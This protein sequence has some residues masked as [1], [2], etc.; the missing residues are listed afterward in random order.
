MAP[1]AASGAPFGAPLTTKRGEGGAL[2]ILWWQAPTIL[3]IHTNNG[4]KDTD[5]ASIV[6]EPL[7]RIS[8][9]SL[10]PDIPVLAKEIPSVQ[11]GTIAADYTS[12]TWKLKD[13]ITWSDGTPFTAEDVKYTFEYVM[14]PKTGSTSTTVYSDISKVDVLDPTTVKVTFKAPAAA[15]FIPFVGDAGEIVPK[16]ILS[17]CPDTRNCEFNTK[18]I[19]TGPYVVTDFKPGDTVN[20]KAN[21]K[22]REPNA[23]YFA[24]IEMKGGG[25]ATTAAKAVQTGQTDYAWNLQVA[26]EIIKQLQDAGK[27]VATPP[28][29]SVEQI[30]LNQADPRTETDGELSSA[31][32]KNP[33]FA[34]PMVRKAISYAI[35]RDSIAKNLY[36]PA[37]T[38]GNTIIPLVRGDVGKA[39]TYDLKKAGDLLDQAGWK[40]GADGIREKGGVK[41]NFTFRTSVNPVRDKTGQ[42]M[43]DSFKQLGIGF[44]LKPVD[45]SVFFGRPDNPDALSRFTVDMEM[46]STGSTRPDPQAFFEQMTTDQFATK[47]NNWGNGNVMKWSNPDYDKLFEQLKRELDPEK[48]KVLYNKLDET[49]ADDG[50]IIPIVVR[51]DVFAY[52][53]DLINTQFSPFSSQVWNI[54]HWSLKK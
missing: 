19:G 7:A 22:F 40:K 50:V 14:E 32:S 23:P 9:T 28:G 49:L 31:K 35:D 34:D 5:A 48:R 42:V 10:V 1:A 26:P 13:G 47:A 25:D 21:D 45:A 2:R 12:V 24:T 18:P 37:G 16:H 4:T 3:N 43:K 30:R 54:G 17:K 41:M 38:A 11:A 46:Y 36:G 53:P 20:Y 29:Y 33:F 8:A 44:E 52:R 51:K 15:W 39:F 6:T 27:T